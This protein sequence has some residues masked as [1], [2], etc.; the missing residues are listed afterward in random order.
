MDATVETVSN[1]ERKM[2]VSVPMT[3]INKEVVSRLGRMTKTVKVAGFRPGK[4][5][6][7]IVEKQYGAQVRNEVMSDAIGKNLGDALQEK[8]LRIA[9]LPKIDVETRDESDETFAFVAT[10][11]VYPEVQVKDIKG[12]ELEKPTV[13]IGDA[14]VDSTLDIMRKQRASFEPKEKAAETGDQVKLDFKGTVDGE[15][16]EGGS[17]E[18]A[19][20]PIGEGRLVEDFEKAILGVKAGDEKKFD[21]TFPEDYASKDLAGKK[22]QFEV[23]VHEVLEAVLPDIDKAFAESLGVEN[24]DVDKLRADVK[25]NVETEAKKRLEARQKDLVMK[26]LLDNS[27]LELP[28]ALVDAEVNRLSDQM[29]QNMQSRGV[30]VGDAPFPAEVFNEEAVRRVKLGLII[31]HVVDKNELQATPDRLKEVVEEMAAGY[32]KPQEVRD[33]YYKNPQRLREIESYV[34]EKN[35]VDWALETTALKDQPV[36]FDELMGTKS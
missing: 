4:V 35:V 11:E 34:L 32:E 10:F 1:L 13:T 25:Q 30:Q 22:A 33:W 6:M 16:F 9:G 2:S 28:K 36:A 12:L 7:K 17:A 26:L 14:E 18:N 15:A 24:G 29:K 31:A 20:M 19:V 21:V 8:D 27:E 5:P 23:K 3:E